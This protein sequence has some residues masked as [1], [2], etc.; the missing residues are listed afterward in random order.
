MRIGWMVGL[1]PRFQVQC[2]GMTA[3]LALGIDQ[4]RIVGIDPADEAVAAAEEQPVVVDRAGAAQRLGRAS[5]AAVVLQAAVD[6]VQR[7]RVHR[8]W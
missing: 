8:T 5:P 4:V 1:L 3:M 7:P 6:A 2:A